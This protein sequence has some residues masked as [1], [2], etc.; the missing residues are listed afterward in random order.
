M[1]TNGYV[2]TIMSTGNEITTYM[3]DNGNDTGTGNGNGHITNTTC[4]RRY[5]MN[6]RGGRGNNINIESSTNFQRES[7]DMNRQVLETHRTD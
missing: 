2:P 6:Y 1:S 5:D 4:I 3:E 7:T